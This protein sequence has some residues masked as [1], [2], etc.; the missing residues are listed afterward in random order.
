MGPYTATK[1]GVEA[2]SDAL[3][4]ETYPSGARVGCAYFGFIDT[5]L[6]R[7]AYAQPATEAVNRQTPAFLRDPAPLSTAVD[8]IERGIER[9]SARVWAPR[10]VGT[11]LALRGLVQSLDRTA[12]Q[13]ATQL[14][15]AKRCAWPTRPPRRCPSPIR[16]SASPPRCSSIQA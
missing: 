5:D 1:A 13:S 11:A 9:R 10:W 4:M 6:V 7:A 12:R 8:A 3:R 14:L 16:C 15:S 2:L